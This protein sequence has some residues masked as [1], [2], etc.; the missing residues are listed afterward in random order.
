MQT[1]AKLTQ[2]PVAATLFHLSL[3]MVGGLFSI[4]AF[5][6]ADTYFVSQLGTNELAAMSFTFPMVMVLFG[7]AMGLSTGT[8]AVVSQAIGRGDTSGVKRLVSDSLVLAFLAVLVTAAIGIATIDPLFSLLGA[9]PQVLPLIREYMEIWYLGIVFLVVPMVANAAIRATGDT[10]FPAL[11]MVLSTAAN[12]IL[13]PI[14]IFGWFGVPAL[15]LQGA[16][17]ATLIAR[18]GT[19]AAALLILHYRD[20]LLDFSPP[21]LGQVWQSWKEVGHI[22]LPA[23]ATNWLQPVGLGLVTRLI[24]T[25]GAPA[26]AAWGAGSRI[27]GIALIPVFALC[28]G[29][30]PFIGQNWGAGQFDRVKKGR[31]YGYLFALGW[32][33]LLIGVLRLVAE[34]VAA[35]FSQDQAVIRE[36]VRYLWIIPF[37]FAMVGILNI[38]E[39]TLNAI[40]K[41]IFAS[42]QTLLHMF[43]FFIPL[44]F[45][46]ASQWAV[47]GLLGGLV[48]AD[49][50]GG[51]V[52][53]GLARWMCARGERACR[54]ED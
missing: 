47:G 14:L 5:N 16:A 45:I 53:L 12:I 41:P 26:V 51:L 6:L 52:G 17:I 22:A 19:M 49:V 54:A 8:I 29:L 21:N 44:A 40:G 1:T 7:L 50:L 25:Y 9:G 39:E 28:S 18:A 33:L 32:G 2:G 48:V 34:P 27:S 31:S 38:T 3:P 24:A 4:F 35:L 36:I 11:M 13:D 30:V 43:L 10:K 23:T 37:G 42:L 20:R 15:G 46:G